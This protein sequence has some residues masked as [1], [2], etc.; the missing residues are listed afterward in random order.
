MTF[1]QDTERRQTKQETQFTPTPPKKMG[2][3][4][5]TITIFT[6]VYHICS[7]IQ[8]SHMKLFE[9]TNTKGVVIR[10]KA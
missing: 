1:S 5:E 4:K 8:V 6:F 10:R 7:N 9:D 2:M 3:K